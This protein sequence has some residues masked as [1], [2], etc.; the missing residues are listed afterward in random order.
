VFCFF[1]HL[2]P[3]RSL[4]TREAVLE[5]VGRNFRGGEVADDEEHLVHV[6]DPAILDRVGQL[7]G[8]QFSLGC[9][10]CFIAGNPLPAVDVVLK[11]RIK[12]MSV[13]LL[14]EAFNSSTVQSSSPSVRRHTVECFRTALM[15]SP[16]SKSAR[17]GLFNA[18]CGCLNAL[19]E[20]DDEGEAEDAVGGWKELMDEARAVLNDCPKEQHSEEQCAAAEAALDELES[21]RRTRCAAVSKRETRKSSSGNSEQVKLIFFPLFCLLF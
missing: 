11:S 19:L 20:E 7:L 4:A 6:Q 15:Q 5:F 16:S 10:T 2:L 21:R 12:S 14:A 1:T 8:C 18:L 3:H 9:A 13:A 17:E